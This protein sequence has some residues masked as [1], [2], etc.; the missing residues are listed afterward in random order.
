MLDITLHLPC[1]RRNRDPSTDGYRHDGLGRRG[2]GARHQPYTLALVPALSMDLLR[3]ALAKVAVQSMGRA[4]KLQ[5]PPFSGLP[6]G[7]AED[8]AADDSILSLNL[9]YIR[10]ARMCSL[11]CC[12]PRCFA[13]HC[14]DV[15]WSRGCNQA[16]ALVNQTEVVG[17][18][19]CTL[20][21]WANLFSTCARLCRQS[22]KSGCSKA[23]YLWH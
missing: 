20:A 6:I 16:S 9:N 2:I 19:Y 12:D 5:S 3:Q 4:L 23:V 13:L 21:S 1:L 22:E 8:V 7:L 10:S 14:P 15:R 18:H 17:C 11:A